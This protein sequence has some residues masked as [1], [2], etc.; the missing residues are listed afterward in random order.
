MTTTM[1]LKELQE[2]VKCVSAKMGLKKDMG[3]ERDS[4]K[5]KERKYVGGGEK[6]GN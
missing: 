4:L 5:A 2:I 3:N 1:T 6:R